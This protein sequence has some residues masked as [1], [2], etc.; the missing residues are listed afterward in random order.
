MLWRAWRVWERPNPS[1]FGLSILSMIYAE[2]RQQTNV[3][4]GRLFPTTGRDRIRVQNE[5][6]TDNPAPFVPV[7]RLPI[8]PLEIWKNFNATCQ[9]VSGNL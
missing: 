9:S 3:G 1:A 4:G 2:A 6:P 8:L 7:F 5:Y